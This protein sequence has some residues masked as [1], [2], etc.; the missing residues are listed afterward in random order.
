VCPACGFVQTG[1]PIWLEEAYKDSINACDTGI[2]AR[3]IRL[4]EYVSI[5]LYYFFN[6][7]VRYLDYA[8][9]YGIFTRLMRDIGFDYYWCDKYSD[10]IFAKGFE[11][12]LKHHIEL[13]TA[14][15]VLEHLVTPLE[16][17]EKM[18]SISKNILFTTELLPEP[19]PSP[20]EWWYY[21]IEHGQHISFYT[22]ASLEKIAHHF[23]LNYYNYGDL[24]LITEKNISRLQFKMV[25]KYSKKLN[26]YGRIQR[27]LHSKTMDDMNYVL[28]LSTD[29]KA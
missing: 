5:I 9:G 4:R 26:L 14:F 29:S 19:L 2:L 6:Q 15:E 27:K 13:V 22:R 23:K 11:Y 25:M 18:I 10:N 8:G 20:Q 24:H 7:D 3:N 1:E 16:D 21:G 28:S 12:D 17:L